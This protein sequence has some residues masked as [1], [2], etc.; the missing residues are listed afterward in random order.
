[1][2]RFAFIPALALSLLAFAGC[3][4]ETTGPG[5]SVVG[6]YVLVSVNGDPLPA[7]VFEGGGVTSEA[8]EGTLTLR[9][10]GTFSASTITRNTVNGSSS[11]DTESSSGAY[12]VSG[13]TITFVDSTGTTI[14]IRSGD[15]ITV[16][17]QENG[18]DIVLVFEK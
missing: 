18:L 14:A 5:D 12:T 8:L 16:T 3:D 7:V 2:L 9:A 17:F 1:M 6:T 11:T 10:D 4:D 13:A 15:T